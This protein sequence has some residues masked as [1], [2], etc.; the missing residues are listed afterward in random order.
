VFLVKNIQ[1]GTNLYAIK[2]LSKEE[3]KKEEME[4][5]VLQ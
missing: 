1:Y 2:C 3:I 5:S 4:G